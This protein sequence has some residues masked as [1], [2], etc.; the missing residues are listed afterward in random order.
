MDKSVN[1]FILGICL[2]GPLLLGLLS[3]IWTVILA[4]QYK[5]FGSAILSILLPIW[6]PVYQVMHPIR[7]RIPLGAFVV[8]AALFTLGW[9]LTP[10][11]HG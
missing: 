11:A 1:D 5:D 2:F 4:F 3:W 8:G 10:P 7:C 9:N 6:A